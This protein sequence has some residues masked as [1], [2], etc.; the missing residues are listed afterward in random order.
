MINSSEMRGK[1]VYNENDL[2]D[3]LNYKTSWSEQTH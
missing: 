1:K 3:F 2:R